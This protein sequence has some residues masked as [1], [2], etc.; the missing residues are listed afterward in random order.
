L[1]VYPGLLSLLNLSI[2]WIDINMKGEV[3]SPPLQII[4][5]QLIATV[6]LCKQKKMKKSITHCRNSSKI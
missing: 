5:P 6:I 4:D 2:A 1:S 3:L